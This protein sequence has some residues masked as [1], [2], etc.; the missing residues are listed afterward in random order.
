MSKNRPP[1]AMRMTLGRCL[2]GAL[3][4]VLPVVSYGLGLGSLKVNSAL[5]EP[6]NAEIDFTSASKVELKSLNVGLAPR[7]EFYT[8]G[9]ER[10]PFLA[11]IKFTVAKRLDGRPFLQLSTE[12]PVREPFLHFL[13]QAEWAGGRMV[14]EFTALIDPPYLVAGRPP[15]VS[16]PAT[17]APATAPAPP[18]V[19]SAAPPPAPA[20][21]ET[22]VEPPPNTKV[23]PPVVASTPAME[24]P[25]PAMPAAPEPRPS[26]PLGPA[27]SGE[28]AIS[29]DTGWPQ[30][31]PG[32]AA[33]GSSTEQGMAG[34]EASTV[35]AMP[36]PSVARAADAPSWARVARYEVKR[37]DTLWAI[38]QYVGVDSS[39]T[40]EQIVMA[41]FEANRDAFFR[42]NVNNVWAGEVLI[43]PERDEVIAQ[44]KK[45]AH[46]VFFAQY[47]EWQEY[48]QQLAQAQPLKVAGSEEAPEATPSAA[49]EETAKAETMGTASKPETT[50]MPAAE[51]TEPAKPETEATPP[52]PMASKQPEQKPVKESASMAAPAPAPKPP[53]NLLKIVRAAI[54]NADKDKGKEGGAGDASQSER[55]ALAERATT[56]DEALESKQMEQKE[57]GE[58]IDTVGTQI[59]RQK[60]LIE[61]DNNKLAKT[62]E[63]V[64]E[65][66]PADESK[67]EPVTSPT[68][69][70]KPTAEAASAAGVAK[71]ATEAKPEAAKPEP[72]KRPRRI[73]PTSSA[74]PP[75]GKK[76]RRIVPPQPP[77]EEKGLIA[78]LK[79]MVGDFLIQGVAFIVAIALGLTLL[80][81][82]RRRRQAEAEF[83]ESILT[84]SD[85]ITDS[86]TTDSGAQ[87]TT[88]AGSTSF[89]SDFSQG[90]MGNI[91]TDEVDP[92]A[93]TEVYLAYGRDEQAE[94]ILKD[95]VTKDPSR[96]ELKVKLLEIYHQRNDVPAFETLAEELYAALEGRGGELWNKV[97]EM[98]RRLNPENPMFQ[99]SAVSEGPSIT[100]P[101]AG[102]P[103]T[104][105]EAE[106][107]E[108]PAL[109]FETAMDDTTP[110]LELDTDTQE[111]AAAES[112]LEFDL[113]MDTGTSDTGAPSVAEEPPIPDT[114]E[115][116]ADELGTAAALEQEEEEAVG[117]GEQ[118][119]DNMVDFDI[120]DSGPTAGDTGAEA[121]VADADSQWQFE[122]DSDVAVDEAVAEYA[123]GADD[124]QQ[125]DETATKLD[126]AKAYVDMGD[127]EGARSILDE[128]L[129]EGNEDQKKQAAELAAQIA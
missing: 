97:A 56:L 6:L 47:Q 87:A 95:A 100:Q 10:I 8:A 40:T 107:E 96:Q 91:S 104:Q 44:G 64:G 49:T 57:L 60:R 18:P 17:S 84:D 54:E 5:N 37:G 31:A 2:I 35:T 14:R 53:G 61:L 108:P 99:V 129:A 43:M 25:S 86:P 81:Y 122:S 45:Q 66:K 19:A 23:E 67:A 58:R 76:P 92:L 78:N 125:W 69:A 102:A 51:A 73:R 29:P 63:A 111:T 21:P 113:D 30:A 55:T 101:A 105:F 1:R 24:Q 15:T 128:V 112:G 46:T 16:A 90:G 34:T 39:L 109:E 121:A 4:L 68:P 28:V 79:D 33:G 72:R 75:G 120:T 103:P 27:S 116:S 50:T 32:A 80:V 36:G 127:A 12:Q 74:T 94:E 123:A 20:T 89:L 52:K 98:G 22:L 38:A 77:A 11:D 13:V 118:P 114:A 70:E 126:L 9:V 42:N 41:L 48:K 119:T 26:E 65:S 124:A 82:L 110:G 7:S 59:A 83:E 115:L 3:V 62:Q 85:A 93:E 106:P 117:L 88:S 71:E